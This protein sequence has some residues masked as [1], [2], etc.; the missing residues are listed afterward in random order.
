[1]LRYE[2]LG[3]DYYAPLDPTTGYRLASSTARSILNQAGVATGVT[4]LPL[5]AHQLLDPETA[6]ANAMHLYSQQGEKI[7]GYAVN[8]FAME[9]RYRFQSGPLRGLQLGLDVQY[10]RDIRRYYYT[11]TYGDGARKLWKDP[12]RLNFDASLRYTV[13]LAKGRRWEINLQVANLFDRWRIIPVANS[14]NGLII[15]GRPYYTPRRFALT[16]TFRF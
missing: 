7:T 16:N 2:D 6:A 14:T 15:L 8:T 9:N 13:N 12:A 10:S 5:T 11:D 3:G 4:G 1:M